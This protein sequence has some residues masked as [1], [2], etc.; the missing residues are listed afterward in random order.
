MC[1]NVKQSAPPSSSRGRS[2]GKTSLSGGKVRKGHALHGTKSVPGDEKSRARSRSR[3][4]KEKVQYATP[5]DEK[6]RCHYHKSV[7]L[8]SKR[9]S[10]GWKVIYSMCPKCMEEAD[11]DKSQ[12]SSRSHKSSSEQQQQQQQ[13]V[14]QKQ[15]ERPKRE[16]DGQFDK[17]GCCVLHS[18]IQVAKKKVLGGWKVIRTCPVCEGKDVGLDDDDFSICSGRSAKSTK[19][20][21]STKSSSRGKRGEAVKSDKYGALPFDGEGYCCQHPS[22]RIAKKKTIGGWKIIHSVCPDCAAEKSTRPASR[23]SRSKSRPRSKSQARRRSSGDDN[24]SDA[25]YKSGKSGSSRSTPQKRRVRVKNLK[26]EDEYEKPG[27]YWGY[28]DKDYRPNGQGTI[29]YEDGTEW[30]GVWC[31]GSRINGK[32]KKASKAAKS[33]H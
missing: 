23:R 4:R 1:Q 21:R 19:S 22:V 6:G 15:H 24:A 33:K 32:L 28:V 12:R 14:K 27:R 20:T 17:N 26:T 29:K 31:E 9:M 7:Q 2:H 8:A 16:A 30:D 5:F 10:G 11:D 13:Q 25:S 18:H 3:T